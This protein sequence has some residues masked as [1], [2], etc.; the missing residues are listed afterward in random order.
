MDTKNRGTQIIL[1]VV[2]VALALWF[3]GSLRGSVGG[4]V[5]NGPADLESLKEVRDGNQQ[6]E[7]LAVAR[8]LYME[9]LERGTGVR[10][11]L[12]NLRQLHKQWSTEMATLPESDE[13]RFIAADPE[14][15]LA[16][17]A[18]TT[19]IRTISDVNMDS[20]ATRLDTL[21]APVEAAVKSGAIAGT[22]SAELS[23][24]L[25]Q[26]AAS[27]AELRKPYEDGLPAIQS[28]TQAAKARGT[29]SDQTLKSALDGLRQDEAMQRAD[30][31]EA[32]RAKAHAD[33]SHKLAAAQEALLRANGA[34]EEQA[35]LD[36][37]ERVAAQ[38]R[39]DAIKAK[40]TNPDTLERL[41]PLISKSTVAFSASSP[42][43]ERWN[44]ELTEAI[45]HSFGALSRF[46]ALEQTENGIKRLHEVVM[47]HRSKRPVW[48]DAKTPED[49]A[50][51]K[52]NQT[53]L[54]EL[55]PT[56]VELGYLAI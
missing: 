8:N 41:R 34:R 26:L 44:A 22:P 5:G 48:V 6:Q 17:R 7:A 15:V 25:A 24:G 12:E 33:V 35:I 40:A 13:G 52:E 46:G 30:I 23:E 29:R 39:L 27:I 42:R 11:D 53:L 1:A 14:S 50:W 28:I 2:G 43:H 36:E 16:F 4:S 55:G 32:A 21:L 38:A 9:L 3:M 20:M 49:W 51:I 37:A 56:L 54:R 18:H 31:I 19:T 45:P 47:D 10:T